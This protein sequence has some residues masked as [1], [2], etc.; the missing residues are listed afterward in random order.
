MYLGEGPAQH[1]HGRCVGQHRRRSRDSLRRSPA[2]G[3]W[4]PGRV[5]QLYRT[6]CADIPGAYSE[7]AQAF[8]NSC[9]HA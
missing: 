3:K 1:G 8:A 7:L 2:A 5:T 9:E 4:N 6:T